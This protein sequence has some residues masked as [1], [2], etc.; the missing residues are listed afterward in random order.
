MVAGL[1]GATRLY[2]IL[3]DP[4]AQAKSPEGLTR[5]FGEAGHDAAVVPMRV[6]P[7]AIAAVLAALDRV[8]NVDGIVATVPHKFAAYRH[9]ASASRRARLIGTANVLRRRPDGGWHADML[10]GLSMVHAVLRAGGRLEGR[11]ALL[12]GAG[13][14][15]CAIGLALLE[16]GVAALAVHD[17]DAARRERLLALL[18]EAYPGRVRAGDADPAGMDVVVNAT[19]S[20]M[21]DGDR[22]SVLFERLAPQMFVADVITAP[23][24]TPLLAAAQARGARIATGI[25]MFEAGVALMLDFFTRRQDEAR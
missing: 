8:G 1:S 7:D 6:P 12:A 23:E 2:P 17:T 25:G 20:G 13:G 5:A 14:A 15:G 21:R 24:I 9:A 16:A 10:D 22:P 3:G 4:I 11:T 19:P 18:R